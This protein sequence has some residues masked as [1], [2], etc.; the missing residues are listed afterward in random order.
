MSALLSYLALEKDH[1]MLNIDAS[2]YSGCLPSLA[3]V[4]GKLNYP[5]V[6][7]RIC[8]RGMVEQTISDFRPQRIKGVARDTV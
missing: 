3:A 5:L 8:A 4:E 7:A 1:Q 6:Q 2:I